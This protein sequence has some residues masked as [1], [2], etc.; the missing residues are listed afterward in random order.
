M[1][2]PVIPE[3]AEEMLDQGGCDPGRQHAPAGMPSRLLRT[4]HPTTHETKPANCSS[5]L[6]WF[7]VPAALVGTGRSPRLCIPV[8]RYSR[9]APQ[10][11]TLLGNRRAGHLCPELSYPGPSEALKICRCPGSGHHCFCMKG[12]TCRVQPMTMILWKLGKAS[13]SRNRNQLPGQ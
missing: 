1:E 13:V 9:P 5:D 8:E 2:G 11:L 3:R 7:P 12:R 4:P 10:S 6:L